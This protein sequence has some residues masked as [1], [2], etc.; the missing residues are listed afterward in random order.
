MR[1][2]TLTAHSYIFIKSLQTIE[3]LRK[4]KIKIQFHSLL[5][6]RPDARGIKTITLKVLYSN[7]LMNFYYSSHE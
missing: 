3:I 1:Y 5:P 4:Y 7:I 2:I 6:I